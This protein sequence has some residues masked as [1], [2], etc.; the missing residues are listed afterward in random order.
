[1]IEDDVGMRPVLRSR[2]PFGNVAAGRQLRTD[3][4]RGALMQFVMGDLPAKLSRDRHQRERDQTHAQ[5]QMH[6][7]IGNSPSAGIHAK[8]YEGGG[9]G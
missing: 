3:T 2:L 7:V 8:R 9:A 1:V 5:N 4:L 6:R